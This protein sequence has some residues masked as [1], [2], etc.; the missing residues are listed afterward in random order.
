MQVCMRRRHKGSTTTSICCPQSAWS[1]IEPRTISLSIY[2]PI[3]LR[4]SYHFFPFSSSSPSAPIPRSGALFGR[5][6]AQSTLSITCRFHFPD[7]HSTFS[8]RTLF[9]YFCLCSHGAVVRCKV[10]NGPTPD[11]LSL[12]VHATQSYAP[13]HTAHHTCI[14]ASTHPAYLIHRSRRDAPTSVLTTTAKTRK[15]YDSP[16]HSTCFSTTRHAIC[17]MTTSIRVVAAW[18]YCVAAS[19]DGY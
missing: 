8:R 18:G 6:T 2:S 12:N 5:R 10:S 11:S 3:L 17:I 14:Y 1:L 13:P 7:I 9:L 19:S 4:S 15:R 16:G